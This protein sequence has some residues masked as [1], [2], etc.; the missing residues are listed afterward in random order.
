MFKKIFIITLFFSIFFLDHAHAETIPTENN[1]D[2]KS[3]KAFQDGA[4]AYCDDP[5][6]AWG[7]NNA[8]VPIPQYPELSAEAVTTQMNRTQNLQN[9]SDEQKN[10]LQSE[11]STERIGNFSGFKTLEVARLQYRAA[12]NSVFACGIVESRLTILAGLRE[13]LDASTSSRKSEIQTQL[14]KEKSRLENE[15]DKLKCNSAGAA[16]TT[17]MTELVNST[18]R[19]YCHYRHYLSYL[20]TNL[21]DNRYNIEQIEKNIGTGD[22]TIQARTIGEWIESYNRYATSLDTEINRADSS[23]PR[24]IQAYKD[25]E[26]A[27][28]VHLMLTI[29]YDDFIRLRQNLSTYMNASTQLYLKAYN[30]Q[31]ANQR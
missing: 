15:R 26:K 22:G 6:R 30:A 21:E 5:S 2:Y 28:P 12:M 10:R 18:T 24:A 9:I 20:D 25:M 3:Y 8:L 1:P 14:D 27:Y 4:K 7:Q 23:L 29:I 11:L 31:D 13:A 17:N 19:Q 16:K